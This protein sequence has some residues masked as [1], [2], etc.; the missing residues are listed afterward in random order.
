MLFCARYRSYP[1]VMTGLNDRAQEGKYIWADSGKGATYVPWVK[2]DPNRRPGDGDCVRLKYFAKYGN[3]W[4]YAD[5]GC[6]DRYNF[7]CKMPL[8]RGVC[9]GA[10]FLV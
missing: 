2:G 8:D 10:V 6:R 3:T 5:G 9:I 4:L 7:I 1:E